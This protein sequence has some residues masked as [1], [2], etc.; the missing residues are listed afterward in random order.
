[1]TVPTTNAKPAVAKIETWIPG[2]DLIADGGLPEQRTT[3]ITGTAGSGKTIFVT[4]FLAGGIEHA[5]ESGVFV[6]FEDAPADIRRNV[7]GFG[8]DIERWESEG[9]WAFVDATPQAAAPIP[10]VGSFDLGALLSR[11]EHAVRQVGAK[12][13][14]LDSM[15]ALSLQIEDRALLRS[16]IFRITARLKE[17]G[18][19]VV[20]TGE[21]GEEYGRLTRSGIEEFVADNVIVLRNVLAEERR[22]RTVEILKF[23][24]AKHQ[25]GEVPFT[26][27]NDGI[28]VLPL[29]ALELTHSSSTRRVTSGVPELD[30]MCGGGFF[31]NSIVLVSGA[32]GTGKTLLVTQFLAGG[33]QKG[34]RVLLFA[35][36][37]S[38][39]Q[40]FRNA[41]S[42]GMDFEAMAREGK[43]RGY[44]AYPHAMPMEDHLIQMQA[45]IDEFKPQRVAVDSLS[46]LERVFTLKGY[47]EF[48]ISLTS[49][50]KRDQMTGL[51]T[52][53]TASL[54]GGGS[55][56]EKHIS[57]L[58]DS[59]ILLRYVELEGQMRRSLT[60]LKMR[61][62]AHDHDIRELTIDHRGMHI[63]EAFRGVMGILSGNQFL[64]PNANVAGVGEDVEEEAERTED[65]TVE[66]RRG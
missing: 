24:G 14:A 23:R 6:T 5:G 36:E 47:R 15:N 53:T 35:F 19:T 30:E 48:V 11:I 21:R 29:T 3:L 57:T 44:S 17:L 22:R 56:T 43:L 50:L 60:V 41:A 26:I 1:M 62:S 37:E 40:L 52:S 58:T 61:G 25:R 12:R 45:A 7:L 63:G 55:V 2:F 18:L 66:E 9:K 65:F 4:Q 16:E 51:F 38:R 42:W 59:I 64:L 46:A 54:L 32:T 27:S 28:V 31:R 39:D 33:Y 20:F 34:E 13:I 49:R 8:W 10:V